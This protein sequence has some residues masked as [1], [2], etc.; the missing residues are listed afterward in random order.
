MLQNINNPLSSEEVLFVQTCCQ[1]LKIDSDKKVTL[2][3]AL[4]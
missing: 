2:I 1:M 3:A 4:R